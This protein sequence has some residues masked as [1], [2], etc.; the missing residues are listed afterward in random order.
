[1][2]YRVTVLGHIQR[3]GSPTV[4]DRVLAS[5]LGA[6]AVES[7]KD[8]VSNVM[9]GEIHNKIEFTPLKDIWTRKKDVDMNLCKLAEM[10]SI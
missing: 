4:R 5:K 9:V 1:M 6:A 2:N 3:G 7:L 8:G 10:L